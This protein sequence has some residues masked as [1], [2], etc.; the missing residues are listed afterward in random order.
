MQ[1]KAV[2]YDCDGVVIDSFREG[3]RRIRVLAAI[4]DI[5]FTRSTRSTLTKLWGAPGVVLLEKGLGINNTLAEEMYKD[6]EKMDLCDPIP[7]IPGA[8]E[9]LFWARRNGFINCLLTSR[10]RENI[11]AILDRTNLLCEFAFI[12]AREDPCY[13]KPDPRAFRSTLE[14]LE[15]QYRITKDT[16]IFI[17]DTPSDIQGGSNAGLETLVVQTGPYLLKHSVQFPIPLANIL[18]SIDDFPWWAEEHHEGTLKHLY[19]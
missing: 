3:L 13:S 16:C 15:E 5:P 17:G 12:S 2:I 4:H 18:Q 10:N 14:I 7:N 6:W 8:R 1:I 9:V 19:E 11:T